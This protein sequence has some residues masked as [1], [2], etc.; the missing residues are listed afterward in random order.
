MCMNMCI[1][2]K[3][4]VKA[5]AINVQVLRWSG[6]LATPCLWYVGNRHG[7]THA[8]DIRIDMCIDTC[9][10]M[11]MDML[12]DKCMDICMGIRT[13]MCIDVY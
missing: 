5:A 1:D 4:Y 12:S 10:S 9:I 2:K 6:T 13:G 11:R 7:H 8:I 3:K